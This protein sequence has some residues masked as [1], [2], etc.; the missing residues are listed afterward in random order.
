M[1][2]L[3]DEPGIG[4]APSETELRERM[5]VDLVALIRQFREAEAQA[6][7]AQHRARLLRTR[8]QAEKRRRRRSRSVLSSGSLGRTLGVGVL[9]GAGA[10][11]SFALFMMATDAILG[12]GFLDWLLQSAAIVLGSSVVGDGSQP[13]VLIVGLVVHLSLAAVY[14]AIFAVAARYLAF[15]RHDLIIATTVFGFGIWILNFYVFSPWLFPWFDDSPDIV[16]FISHTV[17]YGMPLG[18]ILL[19]FTPTGGILR[20]NQATP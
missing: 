15:L 14:G 18:A 19:E 4:L 8:I 5:P 17:F 11:I 16:Q 3:V 2:K 6:Q 9:A 10:G 13:S 1:P 7:A 20:S 12:D